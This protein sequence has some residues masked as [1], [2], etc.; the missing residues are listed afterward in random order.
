[1]AP[2][3]GRLSLFLRARALARRL[4]G[5]TDC[6]LGPAGPGPR[7]KFDNVFVHCQT[8]KPKN[9]RLKLDTMNLW[10]NLALTIL[11]LF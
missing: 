11:A 5:K 4:G 9:A 8:V 10:Q 3:S 7:S 2:A 6:R 1:M